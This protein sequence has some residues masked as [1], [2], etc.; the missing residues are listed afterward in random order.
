MVIVVFMD[1]VTFITVF[2]VGFSVNAEM[3]T[4][5][6]TYHIWCLSVSS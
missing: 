6:I 4:I 3:A 1:M 2:T 5:R